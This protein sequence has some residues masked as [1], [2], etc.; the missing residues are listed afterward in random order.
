MSRQT[1]ELN[2]YFE[3]NVFVKDLRLICS[4]KSRNHHLIPI[5]IKIPCVKQKISTNFYI[6]ERGAV[7][8]GVVTVCSSTSSESV[9]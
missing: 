1:W 9:H 5:L 2:D 3:I 7:V 6:G 8:S 4:R